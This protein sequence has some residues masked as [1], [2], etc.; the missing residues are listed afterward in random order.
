MHD[1]DLLNLLLA[2]SACHRSRLLNHKEPENRIAAYVEDVF[3]RLRSSLASSATISINSIATSIMLA[4]LE[5]ISPGAFGVNIQWY[6]HLQI[7]REMFISRAAGRPAPPFSPEQFFLARWF[8]YL[9]V[10]GSLSGPAHGAPLEPDAYWV[11]DVQEPEGTIDCFFGCTRLCMRLLA[12]VARLVKD[13]EGIR[14]DSRRRVRQQWGPSFECQ[15]R[16]HR[17]LESLRQSMSMHVETCP[18]GEPETPVEDTTVDLGEIMST[19]QLYHWAGIIHILRR[20]LNLPQE[21]P[22]VLEAVGAVADHLRTIRRNSPAEAC[23]VFPIFSAAVEATDEAVRVMFNSRMADLEEFGMKQVSD[24]VKPASTRTSSSSVSRSFHAFTLTPQRLLTRPRSSRRRSSWSV[25]GR[26]TSR[27]RA[28]CG[29]SSLGDG[30]YFLASSGRGPSVICRRQEQGRE[31]AQERQ[32][33]KGQGG[34]DSRQ[35]TR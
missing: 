16:A 5:I 33:G 15:D 3:P 2:Y 18:H 11:D 14:L 17:L 12:Q 4:S 21:S 22:Q 9:D 25:C 27:G 30:R 32:R 29:R 6:K 34:S 26:P 19:N 24:F 7:A 10:L 20:V 31:W 28:W 1:N 35:H 13:T 8:G 23:L